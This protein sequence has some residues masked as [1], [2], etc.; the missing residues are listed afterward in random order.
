MGATRVQPRGGCLVVQR[1]YEGDSRRIVSVWTII[2]RMY[3]ALY[4][5][6]DGT[7]TDF[8]FL[9]GREDWLIWHVLRHLAVENLSLEVGDRPHL[10]WEYYQGSPYKTEGGGRR[11]FRAGCLGGVDYPYL[12]WSLHAL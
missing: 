6:P 8:R 5:V 4:A 3:G 9:R 12:S 11:L 10:S 7:V 2:R 1:F